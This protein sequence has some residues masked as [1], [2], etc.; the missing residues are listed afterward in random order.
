MWPT[1]RAARVMLNAIERRKREFIFTGHGK[2][3]GYIGRHMP[4]FVHF[5][6][7]RTKPGKRL[8]DRSSQD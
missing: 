2:V 6:L 5:V 7:T 8:T 3:S 1:D 4:G